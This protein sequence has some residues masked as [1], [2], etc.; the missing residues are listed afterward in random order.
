V[1]GLLNPAAYAA[2]LARDCFREGIVSALFSI[3][4]AGLLF[5]TVPHDNTELE[6]L[7]GE[8]AMTSFE[9]GHVKLQP[10]YLANY[11][12]TI[13]GNRMT[14]KGPG[15]KNFTNFEIN[16]DLNLD[17][18]HF[19]ATYIDVRTDSRKTLHGIYLLHGD[20]LRVCREE[21]GS[22]RPLEFKPTTDT[23]VMTMKRVKR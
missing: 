12:I 8:W 18:A 9:G 5:A 10:D 19:D 4:A 22:K 14:I 6:C 15:E 7:D 2:R 1:G 23:V 3:T 20:I 17:P 16:I 11:R 13:S 21:G